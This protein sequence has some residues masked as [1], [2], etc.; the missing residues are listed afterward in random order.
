[1]AFNGH[2]IAKLPLDERILK[3]GQHFIYEVMKMR[4][5]MTYKFVEPPCIMNQ[6]YAI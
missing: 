4:N 6:I 1:M 3:I 2:F 5:V